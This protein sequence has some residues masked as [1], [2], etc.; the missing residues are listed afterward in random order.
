MAQNHE[1]RL[2]R[3]RILKILYKAF[4]DGVNGGLLRLTLLQ[5]AFYISTGILR[6]HCDYLAGKGYVEI[7]NT[8]GEED[9][10][11]KLTPKGIDLLES[12]I[13]PDPGIETG[14]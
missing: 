5:M 3:G 11:V 12:N 9:Y 7:H 2:Q 4:P 8:P 1:Y 14:E 6:G 10:I 13:E